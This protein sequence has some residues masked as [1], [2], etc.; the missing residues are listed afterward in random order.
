[1]PIAGLNILNKLLIFICIKYSRFQS[2]TLHLV[3][4]IQVWISAAS[5]TILLFECA[6]FA[7]PS[8]IG[9][10]GGAILRDAFI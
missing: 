1:M 7:S 5:N 4:G 6:K 2:Y 10:P 3:V 8:S 9:G